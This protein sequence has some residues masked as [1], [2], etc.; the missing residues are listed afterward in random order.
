MLNNNVSSL[1]RMLVLKRKESSPN[2]PFLLVLDLVMDLV[3]QIDEDRFVLFTGTFP[4][5]AIIS[6]TTP[7]FFSNVRR[8]LFCWEQD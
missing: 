7:T 1:R 8:F 3:G 6:P 5:D 4:R 2:D